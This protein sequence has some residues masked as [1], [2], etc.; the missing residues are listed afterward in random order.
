MSPR[1]ELPD[2]AELDAP[3]VRVGAPFMPVPFARSLEKRYTP[4]ADRIAAAR[5]LG[6]NRGGAP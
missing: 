3:I 1:R 2:E 4:D 5:V 6:L